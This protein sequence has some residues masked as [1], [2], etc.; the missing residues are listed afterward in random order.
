ME[1]KV[2]VQRVLKEMG[3]ESVYT[4]AEQDARW[5]VPSC[6]YANPE[7]KSVFKLSTELADKIGA[8]NLFSK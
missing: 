7:D 8:K 5:N 4:V 1:L 3:F 2:T 6:P